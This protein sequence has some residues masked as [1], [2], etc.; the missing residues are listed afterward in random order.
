[1]INANMGIGVDLFTNKEIFDDGMKFGDIFDRDFKMNF[2]LGELLVFMLLGSIFQILIALYIER[3]FPG[4]FGIAEPWYFPFQKLIEKY[5][6][7]N[8]S[9][10]QGK[11]DNGFINIDC[12]TEPRNL[13]VGIEICNVKKKFGA[14]TAVN[15]LSMRMFENQI[16]VLLGE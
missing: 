16:T 9:Q 7:S 3:V 10:K 4:E 5:K 8:L 11:D 15:N 2:S 1:M 14:M 13:R 6:K 12:E